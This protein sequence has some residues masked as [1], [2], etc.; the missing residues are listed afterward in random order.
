MHPARV[1]LQDFELIFCVGEKQNFR[2]LARAYQ[3]RSSRFPNRG[4]IVG[5]RLVAEDFRPDSWLPCLDFPCA[6][7]TLRSWGAVSGC[8]PSAGKYFP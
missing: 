4:Q 8:A 3:N 1:A 6:G 2:P 5:M 7:R